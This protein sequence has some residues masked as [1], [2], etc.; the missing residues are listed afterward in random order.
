MG[1]R[2]WFYAGFVVTL[3]L[4]CG[5]LAAR[6]HIV[7]RWALYL[8]SPREMQSA[9]L[10]LDPFPDAWSCDVRVRTFTANA[11]RAFCKSRYELEIGTANDARLAADFDPFSPAA[12]FCF[13]RW[14]GRTNVA[15]YE[16]R[17]QTARERSQTRR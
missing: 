4:A 14:I 10:F 8:G 5:L 7:E 11:E 15:L 1:T 9:H 2:R 6:P 16:G 3:V 12:W 17:T 13:P